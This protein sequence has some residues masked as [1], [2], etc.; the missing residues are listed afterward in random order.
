MDVPLLALTMGDP[1]GIGP[2]VVAKALT[3]PLPAPCLV[4]G[5]V[6]VMRRAVAT[7]GVDWPVA[8][9]DQPREVLELPPRCIGV[10]SPPGMP[11]GLAALPMGQ[12][13]A[14][15]GRAAIRCI[16]AAA[17]LALG[18]GAG[19]AAEGWLGSTGEMGHAL[20]SA[21]VHAGF[22]AA[23]WVV[24][25]D[26]REGW[27]GPALRG[28]GALIVASL[29]A[30]LSPAGAVAYLLIPLV[31]ARDATM[32][33]ARLEWMGWRAPRDWR[34]PFVGAVAGAFLGVHLL[35][36][37]SLM[38]GYLVAMPGGRPYLAAIA[39]DIGANALTAE[40]LF[41]GAIFSA[42]WRRWSFWPAAAVSTGLALVRYLLDPAL[43]QT[44]ELMA[45]AV[46]YTLL[47]G[48]GCCALRAWSGSLLPGYLATVAFFAAYR[49]LLV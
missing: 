12:V 10:W 19:L 44:A 43:P 26:G 39:Y 6:T 49:I 42:L 18:A 35:F 29:A 34:A 7:C 11:A 23:G 16:E 28:A 24:A 14:G 31:I 30:K 4:V 48:L 8:A 22:L 36:A 32:W 15:A 20:A 17:E 47:L 33:R 25:L 1:C 21:S 40:W 9:L 13:Q 2:E 46:F 5:D 45:G 41:R 3:Q 27:R 38:L 37:A